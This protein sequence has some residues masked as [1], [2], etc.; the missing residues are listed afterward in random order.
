M[1]KMARADSHG[2]TVIRRVWRNTDGEWHCTTGPAVEEWTVLPG[3]AHVLSFQGWYLNGV[4]HREGRPA[5]RRWHVGEDGTRVVVWDEW[6]QHGRLHRVGGPSYRSWHVQPDGTRTL[7][8][9]SWYV[10]DRRHR[11]DGSAFSRRRFWWQDK[12][13]EGEDLPWLRRG[14]S[15]L[16][17]SPGFTGATPMQRGDGDGG[18]GGSGVSPAWSRDAR[19]VVSAGDAVVPVYRSAVG[20]SVLL[21][22]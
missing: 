17:A 14:R 9:E 1:Q 7:A 10:N 18:V 15:F 3:G 8:W 16:V 6:K 11:V 2:R 21:C 22:V 19:V 4:L 5:V 20:G 13:V 12:S